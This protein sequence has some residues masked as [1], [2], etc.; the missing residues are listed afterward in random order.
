MALLVKGTVLHYPFHLH[1][2]SQISPFFPQLP[3]LVSAPSRPFSLP[4]GERAT[5]GARPPRTRAG[6]SRNRRRKELRPSSPRRL[7]PL[8]R[9]ALVGEGKRSAYD[10]GRRTTS[11]ESPAKSGNHRNRQR[12]R[13]IYLY[14][15][16][17][18]TITQRPATMRN[19][20]SL[21]SPP[22]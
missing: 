5:E 21:R 19:T 16:L 22:S 18:G 11:S 14:P 10:N 15:L 13:G 6:E 9:A 20:S 17:V 7:R 3:S 8:G 1:M 12:S 4:V 2:I